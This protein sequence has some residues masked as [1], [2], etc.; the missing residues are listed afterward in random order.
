MNLPPIISFISLKGKW[1]VLWLVVAYV[2]SGKLSTLLAIDPGYAAPLFLPAGI[3]VAAVFL[4]G[5]RFLPGVFF[6]AAILNVWIGLDASNPVYWQVLASAFLIALASTLQAGVGG[7]V[8]RRLADRRDL[9]RGAAARPSLLTVLLLTPLICLIGSSLAVS[10]LWAIGSID[11][12]LVL[13][14]GFFWWT[15]DMLGVV[16]MLPLVLTTLSGPR[17]QWFKRA[18]TITLPV[19]LVLVSGLVGLHFMQ[20]AAL[21]NAQLRHA[22]AF[23]KQSQKIR[24][25]I[26]Q[27]MDAYEQVLRGMRGLQAACNSLSRQQFNTY[28]SALNLGQHYPGFQVV[29]YAPW[30]SQKNAAG[31]TQSIRQSGFPTFEIHPPGSRAQ[32]A[33][34]VYLEPFSGRNLQAFGYDMYAEPVR[35]AAMDQA[36]DINQA[37][38][39]GKVRLVQENGQQEQ[40]GVLIYLPEYRHGKLPQTIDERRLQLTGWVYAAFRMNDLMNGLLGDQQDDFGLAIFDGTTPAAEDLLYQSDAA[41]YAA[42]KAA[43]DYTR[44]VEI[45]HRIWTIQI[46]SL[47]AFDQQLETRSVDLIRFG[48]LATTLLLAL[49]VWQLASGRERA[50][51]LAQNMTREM[52]QKQQQLVEAQRIAHIGSWECDLRTGELIWSDELYRILALDPQ[53][54]GPTHT[55][56]QSRVHPDD[57]RILTEA[58]QRLEQE[59]TP[60]HLELRLLLPGDE[61]KYVRQSGEQLTDDEEVA[62]KIIGTLQDITAQKQAQAAVERLAHYDT[63]TQLPNRAL[64][65]D[66]LRMALIKSKRNKTALALFYMDLDGFKQVND[67]LGHRAGDLLLIAVADRLTQTVRASDTVARLGRDEFTVILPDLRRP[68]DAVKVAENIIQSIG[69]PFK[70]QGREVEIGISI[71]IAQCPEK[72]LTEDELIQLAD[73]AMYEAK[74]AGKN[75]YRARGGGNP[76]H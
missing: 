21:N 71:G 33:P 59:G 12:T 31:L 44:T 3:A 32:Y 8:F 23:G 75:T 53:A 41:R 26:E 37:V 30:V 25:R 5:I 47:P 43:F 48:G 61:I 52:K 1:P 73:Q 22:D 13:T 68:E 65:F 63:L 27:R 2:I 70:I 51:K 4:G 49:M 17:K 14:N 64:F 29:G 55:Q 76:P 62:L 39:S 45:A 60:F 9:T 46:F 56:L 10:A 50:L 57:R 54:A 72:R 34:I 28:V 66:R 18:F 19:L 58:C 74:Q 15:G 67:S 16:V 36:R 20:K 69:Q 6:G 7:L 40:S 24:L 35:R 38:M 11:A 42:N